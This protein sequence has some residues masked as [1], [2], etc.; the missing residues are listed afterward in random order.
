MLGSYGQQSCLPSEHPIAGY[1]VCI[2]EDP[3]ITAKYGTVQLPVI[4]GRPPKSAVGL[5]PV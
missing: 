2:P 4:R 3:V 1:S 5:F